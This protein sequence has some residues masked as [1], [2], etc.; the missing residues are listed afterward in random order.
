MKYKSATQIFSH[1]ITEQ[2]KC[3]YREYLKRH[4]THIADI[5]AVFKIF[6]LWSHYVAIKYRW[7]LKNQNVNFESQLI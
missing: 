6:C 4:V 3:A 2:Q 7:S 1:M 5:P